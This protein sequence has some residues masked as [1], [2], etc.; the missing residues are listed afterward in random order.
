MNAFILHAVCSLMQQF[1]TISGSFVQNY[2]PS[3]LWEQI[4]WPS[5]I[6]TVEKNTFTANNQDHK[7]KK[8]VL[9]KKDACNRTKW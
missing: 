3:T 4:F 2:T 6:S 7:N 5:F 8:N 1:R 9:V